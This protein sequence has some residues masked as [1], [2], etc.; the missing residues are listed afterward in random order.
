MDFERWLT[1]LADFLVKAGVPVEHGPMAALGLVFLSLTL[2]SLIVVVLLLRRKSR[3]GEARDD[4]SAESLVEEPETTDEVATEEV[5]SPGEVE[6]IFVEE[7]PPT[8]TA[9]PEVEE[10]PPTL[11]AMPE[12]EEPV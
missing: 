3:P 11:T 12:V 8:L 5:T 6:E 9:M 1:K 7:P 4:V 2:L 10:P